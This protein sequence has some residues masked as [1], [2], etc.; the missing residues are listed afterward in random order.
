MNSILIERFATTQIITAMP[1]FI[2]RKAAREMELK[3][4]ADCVRFQGGANHI[5][6]EHSYTDNVKIRAA[7]G[8]PEPFPD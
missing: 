3:A 1:G 6:C 4:V 2:F 5:P 8:E 7:R